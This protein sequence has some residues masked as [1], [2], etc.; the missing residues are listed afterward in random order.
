VSSAGEPRYRV[1]ASQVT[2]SA[3]SRRNGPQSHPRSSVLVGCYEPAPPLPEAEISLCAGRSGHGF[4]A[5]GKRGDI[6]SEVL[7]LTKYQRATRQIGGHSS[8]ALT[9]ATMWSSTSDASIAM[10]MSS[11]TQESGG[12][13]PG[14]PPSPFG[15]EG[16]S[17]TRGNHA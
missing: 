12:W 13:T 17:M 3:Q 1:E 6:V 14:G 8:C 7:S 10:W 5:D 11:R 15:H 2:K 9:P 16:T 4:P